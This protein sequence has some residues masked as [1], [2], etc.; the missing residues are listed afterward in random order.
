MS[1]RVLFTAILIAIATIQFGCSSGGPVERRW[2]EDVLLDDGTTIVVKRSVTFTESNSW[3]GDAYNAIESAATIAFTGDLTALPP[4]SA[5]LMALVMYRDAATEEWVIVATTTSCQVWNRRGF[6]PSRYWEYRLSH[7]EWREVSLTPASI[8]R[9]ANLLHR[10][11]ERLGTKHITIAERLRR[12]DD[13][14]MTKKY[15]SIDVQSASRNC[16]LTLQN[17]RKLQ[18]TVVSPEKT[19][20]SA[21]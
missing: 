8:G 6:P 19:P 2:T 3:S 17:K 9:S 7:R 4:W 12:E 18:P 14:L 11:Q 1:M 20:T 5:P 10:Y 21:E 15:K 13:P 16:Q